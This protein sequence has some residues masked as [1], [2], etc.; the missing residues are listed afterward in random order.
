MPFAPIGWAGHLWPPTLTITIN[1]TQHQ[2]VYAQ[3]YVDGVTD[4]PGQGAGVTRPVRLRPHRQRPG[5]LDL[6]PMVYNTDAGNNDEY[7]IDFTPEATGS[8]QYLA[9]FS[10][11]L[12]GHWTYAY[13]DDGQR[14]ALTVNPSSDTRRPPR[15][16]NLHRVDQLG[17]LD[18]RRLERQRRAGSLSLRGLAQRHARRP[19]H[20]DRQCA[21]G[22]HA[23]RRPGRHHRRTYYYVV[24][25]QDTSFNRSPNSNEVSGQAQ[26]QMVAVTFTVAVPRR[27]ADRAVPCTSPAA[28]RPPIRSGTRRA[29][30]DPRGRHALD[31]HP[32]HA[33]RHAAWSTNTRWATGTTSKRTLACQEIGNRQ[34]P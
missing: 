10:T 18:H 14:G 19:L 9:R 30:G 26:A 25:A 11:D 8:F 32:Q 12:G 22:H 1:A 29:A 16:A 33:G 17:R 6:E 31:D 15:P 23:I 5:D 7:K 34:L 20:Q 3:V 24:T 28:S 2:T 21:R 4:Q 13:T 27:H